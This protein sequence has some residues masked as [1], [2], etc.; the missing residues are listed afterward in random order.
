MFFLMQDVPSGWKRVTPNRIRT[1]KKEHTA[2]KA[3]A[4]K[5]DSYVLDEFNNVR[6][7]NINPQL[8]ME[9]VK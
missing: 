5:P 1:I 4:N 6:F 2:R 9:L 7:Q 3:C 8:P